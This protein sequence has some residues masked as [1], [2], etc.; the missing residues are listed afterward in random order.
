MLR[1]VFGPG[2]PLTIDFACVLRCAENRDFEEKKSRGGKNWHIVWSPD[3]HFVGDTVG[4]DA[5][6]DYYRKTRTLLQTLY[7][8]FVFLEVI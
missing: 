4:L 3:A 1:V 7:L 5:I 6:L 2:V 8:T